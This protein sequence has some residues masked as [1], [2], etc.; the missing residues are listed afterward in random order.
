MRIKISFFILSLFFVFQ[1]LENEAFAVDYVPGEII[2]KYKDSAKEKNKVDLHKRLGG[3]NRRMISKNME[4][5]EIDSSRD[6]EAV[7]EEY[8]KERIVE[9]AEPNYIL[10]EM[11]Q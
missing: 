4:K 1:D 9:Y 3:K 11:G 10:R 5:I 2:I 7:I 8:K 6:L